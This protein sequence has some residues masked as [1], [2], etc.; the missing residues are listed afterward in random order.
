MFEHTQECFCVQKHQA[1]LVLLRQTH[2]GAARCHDMGRHSSPA[3]PRCVWG[4][5]HS[6]RGSQDTP[7]PHVCWLPP[8]S[9]E[10][11]PPMGPGRPAGPCSSVRGSSSPSPRRGAWR[12]RGALLTL[13]VPTFSTQTSACLFP[14]AHR[15]P[16]HLEAVPSIVSVCLGSIRAFIWKRSV[17]LSHF[18]LVAILLSKAG[19]VL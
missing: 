13:Q 10:P 8:A 1:G 9:G 12:G 17:P 18:S 15:L 7:C 2:R 6:P 16:Q 14:S 4:A 11:P 3:P 5:S 19:L